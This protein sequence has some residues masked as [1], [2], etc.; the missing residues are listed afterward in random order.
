MSFRTKITLDFFGYDLLVYSVVGNPVFIHSLGSHICYSRED[1]QY[2]GKNVRAT[3]LQW[4][5]LMRR[6]VDWLKKTFLNSR[7]ALNSIYSCSLKAVI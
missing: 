5:K 4:W 6:I 7:A 3:D 1:E 2:H